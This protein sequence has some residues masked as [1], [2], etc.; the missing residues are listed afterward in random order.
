MSLS[1]TAHEVIKINCQEC[2]KYH[3]CPRMKGGKICYG[4]RPAPETTVPARDASLSLVNEDNHLTT[5]LRTTRAV[6]EEA[7]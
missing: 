4:M 1:T 5:G 3:D 6:E 7:L 2:V